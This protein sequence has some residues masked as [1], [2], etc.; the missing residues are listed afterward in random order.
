MKMFKKVRQR[1]KETKASIDAVSLYK[2]NYLK[3]SLTRL[4]HIDQSESYAQRN[5]Y[6]TIA[7]WIE[8]LQETKYGKKN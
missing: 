1:N 4:D 2:E 8:A 5:D 7:L 3:Q 6:E